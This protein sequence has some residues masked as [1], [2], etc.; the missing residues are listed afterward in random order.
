ASLRSIRR[1]WCFNPGRKKQSRSFRIYRETLSRFSCATSPVTL[2]GGIFS[3]ISRVFP[4]Q[5][6]VHQPRK[7]MIVAT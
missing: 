7:K 2:L 6:P 5:K 4:S 1:I 3:P